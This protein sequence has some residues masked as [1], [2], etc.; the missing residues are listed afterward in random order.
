MRCEC[1]HD[2]RCALRSLGA[3]LASLAFF[4]GRALSETHGEQVACCPGCGNRLAVAFFSGG[5]GELLPPTSPA[6]L[7]P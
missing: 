5:L 4:D 1:G 2:I 6:N 7:T 3:S